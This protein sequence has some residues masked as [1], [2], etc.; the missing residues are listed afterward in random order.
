[1]GE[2]IERIDNSSRTQNDIEPIVEKIS[3]QSNST[4]SQSE[5][6]ALIQRSFEQAKRI[7]VETTELVGKEIALKNN[8]INFFS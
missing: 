3:N 6:E 5:Q 7:L 1:M 2:F 8:K 4:Q